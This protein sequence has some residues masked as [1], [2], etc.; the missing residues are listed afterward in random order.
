MVEIGWTIQDLVVDIPLVSG[1]FEVYIRAATDGGAFNYIQLDVFVCGLEQLTPAYSTTP[2][3]TFIKSISGMTYSFLDSLDYFN[4]DNSG[5]NTHQD[6]VISEYYLFNL[7]G[8]T[9]TDTSIAEVS[10]SVLNIHTVNPLPPM[11]LVWQAKTNGLV[12]TDTTLDIAVCGYEEV[13]V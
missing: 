5:P 12:A 9:F 4:Y 6:C 13:S 11:Q 8:T 3:V 7:D 1:L 2:E 10:G